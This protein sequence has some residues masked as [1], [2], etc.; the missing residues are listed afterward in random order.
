MKKITYVFMDKHLPE[1][2]VIKGDAP[3]LVPII[4]VYMMQKVYIAIIISI[5][6]TF[7]I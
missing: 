5:S 2:N 6:T 4:R 3:C 7:I 1:N